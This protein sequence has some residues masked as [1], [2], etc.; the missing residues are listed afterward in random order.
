MV[1]TDDLVDQS[2]NSACQELSAE[3]DWPNVVDRYHIVS[4]SGEITLP[5][6][7]DRIMQINVRGVPQVIASPWFQ[8]VAYGPGTEEDQQGLGR[9][10]CDSGM[11]LDRGEF[12]TKVDVPAADGPWKLRVYA[13]VLEA[14]GA[15]CTIQGLNPD[16]EIVRTEV[17]DAWING[18][19]VSLSDGTGSAMHETVEEF[20]SVTVFT[21]PATN[22]YIRLKAWNGI[23]EV[24]LA[25]Y[26]PSDTDPS[27]HRYFS[28]WLDNLNA[29][30]D[31]PLRVVRGRC[32]K[33]FVP[34]VEDT[35]PLIISNLPALRE[36][37]IAIWKR[38]SDDQ[39]N[40]LLHKG[41]AVDLMKKEAAAYRGKSRIP[42]LTFQR[43]FAIG[44]NIPALR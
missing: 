12:P 20:S 9:W 14:D 7:L 1:A 16:G 24:D 42:S 35:D 2:I 13:D 17:D 3:G 19:Q 37:V 27:Y 8:F 11:I 29:A 30:D 33:R 43:G 44:G 22:G 6:F 34:A 32:R 40:Y 28:E 25:A 4:L 39:E 26:L 31:S 5:T 10:W 15:Y 23:T 38:D 18:E 41:T 21:K 36:M